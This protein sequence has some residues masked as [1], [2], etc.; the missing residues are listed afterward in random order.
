MEENKITKEELDKIVK[1]QND[2]YQFSTDV[3]ILEVKKH[4]I[5][6]EIAGVNGEQED[7]K[8]VLEEKYGRININLEDGTFTQI[9]E[10]E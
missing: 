8:K 4:A 3:G 5:L 10:N 9:T 7:Y 1:F 6:H 2:L